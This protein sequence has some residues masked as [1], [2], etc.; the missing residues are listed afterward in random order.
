MRVARRPV[1]LA[2]WT[3]LYMVVM[4]A[5]VLL[6]IRISLNPG[7]STTEL[8][9]FTLRNYRSVLEDPQM[10]DALVQSLTLAILTMAIATPLGCGL[11]LGLTRWPGRLSTAAGVL[12]VLPLALPQTVVATGFFLL[13]WKVFTPLPF[14]S[15]SQLLAHVTLALPV[16]AIV[17]RL[18][19]LSIGREPEE[20]AMDLGASEGQV[21]F[22]V[23]LPLLSPAILAAAAI[24]FVVSLDN[25]VL[26]QWLCIPSDCRTVPMVLYGARVPFPPFAALASVTMVCSLAALGVASWAWVRLRPR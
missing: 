14:D 1:F 22:R 17:V 18:R 10:L 4:L 21:L 8:D 19:L 23:L 12:T 26:S 6:L 7:F 9:G 25:F 5:P 3:W 2:A 13:V 16:V 11:A 15:P 24:A 20:M